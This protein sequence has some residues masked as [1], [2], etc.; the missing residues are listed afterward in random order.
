MTLSA[1]T[2]ILAWV[3]ASRGAGRQPAGE[4]IAFGLLASSLPASNRH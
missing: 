1:L 2:R 3:F 4:P